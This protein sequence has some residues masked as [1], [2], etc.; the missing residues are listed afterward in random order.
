MTL[1]MTYHH[2]LRRAIK[3]LHRVLR[4]RRAHGKHPNPQPKLKSRSL[5][6]FS[7]HQSSECVRKTC[8]ENDALSAI[9]VPAENPFLVAAAYLKKNS[10]LKRDRYV[11]S[12]F[13]PVISSPMGGQKPASRVV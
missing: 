12:K 9:S 1:Q 10:Y 6:P 3:N 7:R 8:S 2:I 4:N 5:K 11:C 13:V